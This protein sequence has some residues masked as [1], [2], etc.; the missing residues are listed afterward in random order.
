[1]SELSYSDF[2]DK[3]L[4]AACAH[5]EA[6]SQNGVNLSKLC[7]AEGLEG[8]S[9]W[10]NRVGADF[11]KSGL[12]SYYSLLDGGGLFK[13]S[14][15]GFERSEVI[16]KQKTVLSRIKRFPWPT[17]WS[18]V[19]AIAAAIAASPVISNWFLNAQTH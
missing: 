10:L 4:I 2:R 3:L 7:A 14:G 16:A 8:Q 5:P 15:K 11:Q 19:A 9:G 18:F 12:G 17:I 1:M 13:P 6:N